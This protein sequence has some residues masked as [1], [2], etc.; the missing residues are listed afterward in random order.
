[1]DRLDKQIEKDYNSQVKNTRKL[2]HQDT[3][4][5]I[6]NKS[7]QTVSSLYETLSEPL[8]TYLDAKKQQKEEQ[9]QIR[10]PAKLCAGIGVPY[11]GVRHNGCYDECFDGSSQSDHL[12]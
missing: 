8:T 11:S 10:Q 6:K 7:K 12:C 2:R 9:K 3:I 1:M 5:A 4:E